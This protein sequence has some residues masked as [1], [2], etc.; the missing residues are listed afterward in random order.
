MASELLCTTNSNKDTFRYD[1][2]NSCH[3]KICMLIHIN[4]KATL[5]TSPELNVQ[6]QFRNASFN[7]FFLKKY[8]YIAIVH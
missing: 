7:I 8:E 5:F 4:K 2:V 3:Y 1:K 6:A